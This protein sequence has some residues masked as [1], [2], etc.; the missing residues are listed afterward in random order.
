ML[1]EDVHLQVMP[2][3]KGWSK[4]DFDISLSPHSDEFASLVANA[5][6]PDNYQGLT[7]AVCHFVR[8]AAQ[9]AMT[10]GRAVHEVVRMRD[11]SETL[12]AAEFAYVPPESIE[13][14]GDECLQRVPVEIAAQWD[15]PVMI[16]VPADSIAIFEP[17]LK[18]RELRRMLEALAVANRP[19]LLDFVEAEMRGEAS[20]GY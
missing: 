11:G 1:I 7:D 13:R 17:P 18:P 2:L 14:I 10:Y 4:R 12:R 8:E 19:E 3:G 9:A 16:R 6:E 15:I 5:L 20:V